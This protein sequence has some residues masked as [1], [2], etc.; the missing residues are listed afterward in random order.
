M[1]SFVTHSWVHLGPWTS[2]SSRFS[3]RL[4]N[5]HFIPLIYSSLPSSDG[6]GSN[7]FEPV[8]ESHFWFWFEFGKFPQKNTNFPI[9]LPFRSK[10]SLRAGSKSI[11]VKDGSASYLLWA[12]ICMGWVGLGQGPSLLPRVK[13][14]HPLRLTEW[15]LEDPIIVA[16][17]FEI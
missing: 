9:F 1:S 3:L 12:K 16:C 8:W 17:T 11:Q 2:I 15:E 4:E 13:T 14:F 5:C 7:I 10:K 6:S